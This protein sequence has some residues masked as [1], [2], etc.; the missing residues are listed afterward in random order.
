MR[1]GILFFIASFLDMRAL[2][3]YESSE[4]RAYGAIL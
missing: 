3:C 2:C 1:V 4:R